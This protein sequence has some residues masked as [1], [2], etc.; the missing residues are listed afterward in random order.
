MPHPL[1]AQ[2]VALSQRARKLVLLNAAARLAAI[3][4]AALLVLG[5]V[6][7]LLRPADQALRF[8]ALAALIA[9]TAAAIVRYLRPALGYRPGVVQMARKLEQRFPRL[10]QRIS[11]AAAFLTLGEKAIPAGSDQLQRMLIAESTA[12]METVSVA[13]VF[14]LAPVKKSLLALAAV[15]VVGGVLIGIDPVSASVAARRLLVPWS[16]TPW[17]RR[18]HLELIDPPHSIARGEALEIAARDTSGRP[19]DDIELQWRSA[20][21]TFASQSRPMNALDDR[22]VSR[23]E[24]ITESL[25]VRVTGGDDNT[26]VW[27]HIEVVD[28]PDVV[29]LEVTV[30]PP[31]YTAAQVYRSPPTLRVLRGS[32]VMLSG[33]AD[34]GLERAELVRPAATDDPLTGRLLDGGRAFR[35]PAG[36]AWQPAASGEYL[37]RLYEIGQQEVAAEFRYPVEVLEDRPPSASFVESPPSTAAGTASITL[38]ISVE[39]DLRVAASRLVVRRA[40]DSGQKSI[41]IPLYEPAQPSAENSSSAGGKFLDSPWRERFE[42]AWN[43]A[44][45]GNTALGAISEGE[46]LIYHLE[47]VDS[48]GQVGRSSEQRL[49]VISLD[50]VHRRVGRRLT[51]IEGKL[52]EALRIESEV[53][54][55]TG[56]IALQFNR[57]GTAGAGDL[58]QLQSIELRQRQVEG[59]LVSRPESA[60]H[61]VREALAEIER[62][63]LEE[64]ATSQRLEEYQSA[65]G[66]LGQNELPAAARELIAALKLLR[67]ELQ[68]ADRDDPAQRVSLTDSARDGLSRSLSAAEANETAVVAELEKLLGNL[69]RWSD[70][71]RF[72]EEL[73]AIRRQQEAIRGETLAMQPD[74]IGRDRRDLSSQL[75]AELDKLALR[76]RELARRFEH[77]QGQMAATANELDA[78][79]PSTAARLGDV[80]EEARG[81]GVSGK[82]RDASNHVDANRLTAAGGTQQEVIADLEHLLDML[83]GRRETDLE[84][85][86][87]ELGEEGAN[88]AKLADQA[89]E[90]ENEAADAGDDPE[91]IDQLN[92]ERD[93]LA[94]EI[95]KARRRLERLEAKEAAD[96]AAAAAEALGGGEGEPSDSEG[97][98]KQAREAKERLRK[99]GEQIEQQKRQA[100]QDLFH[101]QIERLAQ[102]L[103]GFT[104]RERSVLAEIERLD[105]LRDSAGNLTAAQRASVAALATEQ[106]I[107]A[108]E[109]ASAADGL[110]QAAVFQ[111]SL[112]GIARAMNRAAE[113]LTAEETGEPAWNA[114]LEAIAR[115][116]QLAKALEPEPPPPDEGNGNQ[117][118]NPEEQPPQDN[119][120][121][122]DGVKLMAEVKLLKLMQLEINRRTLEIEQSRGPD[123]DLPAGLEQELAELS[124]EQ[125]RVADLFGK[126]LESLQSASGEEAPQERTDPFDRPPPGERNNT[127]PENTEDLEKEL[128]DLLE[129]LG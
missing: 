31:A 98:Q 129:D 57:V 95:E 22:Y 39:D 47:A 123:G 107:L 113:H 71:H 44:E 100:E 114:A 90:I 25:Q 34:R 17:P 7:Y 63:G 59:L 121:P 55:G 28:P 81:H 27:H 43:L 10:G 11:S 50:E 6:D 92:K 53:V 65:I 58:D 8:I 41:S 79:D 40:E 62:N 82:L 88:I 37:V 96:E 102:S 18:T 115:L 112:A 64:T 124:A 69:A 2:L 9:L 73:G 85:V 118:G 5:L 36:E 68:L 60:I 4:I 70:F 21:D 89:E 19:V 51:E 80:L 13:D 29:D 87:G 16:N 45:L 26:M 66:R 97:L 91:K 61:L 24:N 119:R 93:E 111:L 94:K 108:E 67:A 116:E 86:A 15:A 1:Q 38:T 35:L 3:V 84:T 110:K 52:A 12:R 128:D 46:A 49:T 109:T 105:G 101:Q 117:G 33:T 78:T 42:Y 54:G 106:Q 32:R 104:E 120:P 125:G 20:T 14:D 77:L 75:A 56:E 48:L 99:A 122:V 103:V 30:T 127:E 83:T 23:L 126:I 72:A 74:T 76:Q